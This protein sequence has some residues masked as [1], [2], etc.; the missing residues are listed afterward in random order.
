MM[1]VDQVEDMGALVK[2]AVDDL[3]E[4]V[5]NLK[6]FDGTNEINTYCEDLQS[7]VIMTAESLIKK[8]NEFEKEMLKQIES[9][10]SRLISHE[11]EGSNDHDSLKLELTQFSE[12]V[13]AFKVKCSAFYSQQSIESQK[14]QAILNEADVLKRRAKTARRQLRRQAFQGEFLKFNEDIFGFTKNE[15]TSCFEICSQDVEDE[16]SEFA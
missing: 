10:R 9:Y 6:L 15:S 14:F 8:V 3:R 13:E 7:Q 2:S 16:L 11:A 12:E 4:R 1:E 5:Y